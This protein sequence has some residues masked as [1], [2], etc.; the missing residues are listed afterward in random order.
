MEAFK[1]WAEEVR[2][3]AKYGKDNVGPPLRGGNSYTGWAIEPHRVPGHSP[4]RFSLVGEPDDRIR[5]ALRGLSGELNRTADPRAGAM[6][7]N[8]EVA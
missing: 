4:F 6:Y 1:R 5:V 2:S 7:I 3:W 8:A